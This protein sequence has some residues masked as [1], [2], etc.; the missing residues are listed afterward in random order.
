[1][2][3]LAVIY[4]GLVLTL[5]RSMYVLVILRH[6]SDPSGVTISLPSGSQVAHAKT[7]C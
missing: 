6:G 2:P 7:T 4:K 1:M 3:I 5:T